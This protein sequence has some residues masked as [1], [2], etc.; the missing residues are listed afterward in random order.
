MGTAN[1]KYSDYCKDG[2]TSG[3]YTCE[4]TVACC[5]AWMKRINTEYTADFVDPTVEENKVASCP[6]FMLKVFITAILSTLANQVCGKPIVLFLFKKSSNCAFYGAFGIIM[7]QCLC[8][9]VW[10]PWSAKNQTAYGDKTGVMNILVDFALAYAFEL[11]C[12]GNL[13]IIAKY[14]VAK[15][16]GANVVGSGDFGGNKV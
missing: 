8:V 13:V 4:P 7:L 5:T 9:L 11:I 2:D 10:V 1:E 14:A 6:S 15:A 16:M 3:T 12:T